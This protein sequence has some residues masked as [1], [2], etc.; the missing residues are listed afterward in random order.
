[1]KDTWNAFVD[2]D[3]YVPPTGTGMLNNLSFALKDVFDVQ[4]H[5]S[6]AGNPDWLATHQPASE[7]ADVVAALLKEGA[8]LKG[9]THTDELMYGLNGENAHYGTPVNPK[10]ANR[11]PG[12]SSSGSAVAVAAGITDFAIGTDTGGSVRI[13]SSYC[14]IFGYRP[15]HGRISTNGLIPLAPSFDT[16]GVMARDGHTLQK[17]GAVLLNSTSRASGF[18][19]LY[20]ATD[21]MELVDEQSMQALAPPI[22]HVMK[23]FS[24]TEEIVI[25]PRVFLHIWKLF[26]CCKEKK[27][28]KRTE[29]GFKKKTQRLETISEAAFNGRA[30]LPY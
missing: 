9:V 22:K 30:L 20:V 12:G 10:G 29:N 16:V 13:P 5:I 17:V 28:G 25:A 27:F 2:S 6:S 1:M 7:H 18:T 23:S 15:S 21:V 11:I 14:G 8:A 19:R 26:V 24:T 4:G 3:L